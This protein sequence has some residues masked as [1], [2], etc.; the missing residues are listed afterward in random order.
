[1]TGFLKPLGSSLKKTTVDAIGAKYEE[2]PP[3]KPSIDNVQLPLIM[4]TWFTMEE[5]L[6]FF[7]ED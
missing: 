7:K 2:E 4:C 5:V 3:L 6:A 1:M